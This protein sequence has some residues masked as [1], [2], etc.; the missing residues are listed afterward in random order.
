[1]R[2]S[3][4]I[5]TSVVLL[6]SCQSYQEQQ[7]ALPD[8][9]DRG[10]IHVS[11]DETF[12]PII[13][14]QVQVYESN[15]PG[16]HILVDYKTEAD[17]LRDLLNDSVRLI[18]ATRKPSQEEIRLVADSLKYEAKSLTLARDGIAVIVNPASPDTL[19][20]MEEIKSILKGTY[21]KDLTPV[22]DGVKAT[23]TVRFI[24][25]SVLKGGKLTSKAMAARSSEGVIDFVAK[26]KN[27]V[28]F[29]GVGWIGNPEDSSQ[30]S[31]RK[32]VKVAYLESQNIEDNYIKAYQA[33]IYTKRY[34]MV[35][36]IIYILKE[37]HHGLGT[38]F[39]NFMS[40][41]FGQI[42]FRRGYMAPAQKNLGIRPVKL[43]E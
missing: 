11:A 13:D 19:F 1:M 21:Y 24:L 9:P 30:M 12:K 26:N 14:E 10:T 33:N 36:D 28:G 34:P 22:F 8:T 40:G 16:T 35:R 5:I 27:V 37:R 3:I 32:E 7:N 15:H 17:C 29:I 42:I 2:K 39:A 25:D 38:G 20:T 6:V 43:N 41:E 4:G 23:S 18:I 31:F